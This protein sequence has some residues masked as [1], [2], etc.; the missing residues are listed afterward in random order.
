MYYIEKKNDL[1]K[2]CY[3]KKGAEIE[4]TVKINSSDFFFLALI[5]QTYM[6]IH[7]PLLLLLVC[8]YAS[9]FL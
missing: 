4:G 9:I 6:Y 7:L 3:K 1:K 8:A 5:D 2:I